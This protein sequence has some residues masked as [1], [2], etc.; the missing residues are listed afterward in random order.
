MSNGAYKLT[1]TD[2]PPGYVILEN[3][4]YFNVSDGAV[5]LTDDKGDTKEYSN[6]ELL[7]ENTTIAVKNTPG[8]S[9]PNAGG[10]GTKLFYIFGTILTAG[11][12]ILLI[13]RRR[14]GAGAGK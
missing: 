1:E 5:T 14:V 4:I 6:V 13:A 8:A 7:D 3:D 2:A 12:A 9:L 10:P 11:C